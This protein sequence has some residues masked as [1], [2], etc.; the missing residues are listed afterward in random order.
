MELIPEIQ[1]KKN[2][3]RRRQVN[4]H[5]GRDRP[6]HE[7]K[8]GT[9][10][11][12]VGFRGNYLLFSFQKSN[13]IFDSQIFSKTIQKKKKYKKTRGPSTTRFFPAECQSY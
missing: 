7:S 8:K 6:Y 11:F 13:S 1:K 9:L 2:R 12:T 5:R 4:R 10:T 3:H